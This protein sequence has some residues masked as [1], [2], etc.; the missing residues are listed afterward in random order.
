MVPLFCLLC[1]FQYITNF[2]S[3]LYHTRELSCVPARYSKQLV[4]KETR[5]LLVTSGGRG[6]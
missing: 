1:L 3:Q 6:S 5:Q 4:K 2:L